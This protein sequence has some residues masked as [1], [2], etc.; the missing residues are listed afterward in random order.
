MPANA[1]GRLTREWLFQNANGDGVGTVTV[2]FDLSNTGSIRNSGTA[3]DYALLIDTDG[4]FSNASIYTTGAS[5]SGDTISFTGV[6]IADGSYISL[7][8][9]SPT[10]P[11]GIGSNLQLWFK[12]DENLTNSGNATDATAWTSRS[13]YLITLDKNTRPLIG[14]TYPTYYSSLING[15]PG[16]TF[17]QTT[18]RLGVS[19]LTNIP[20][21]DLFITAVY[22]RDDYSTASNENVFSYA[23]GT[24]PGDNEILLEPRP[25][26]T[27]ASILHN[28]G[29][30]SSDI[31]ADDGIPHIAT[32]RRTGTTLSNVYDGLQVASGT[33]SNTLTT[34]G[35]LIL[36]E[37]QDSRCGGFEVDNAWEGDIAEEIVY[38]GYPSATEQQQINSYLALKYGITLDQ[39]TPQDYLASDG[40]TEMWNKDATGASTYS[41]DIAGIGRDELSGLNQTNSQSVESDGMFKISNPSDLDDLEFMTWGNDNGSLATGST[42]IPSS[43]LPVNAVIRLGREW[44]VQNGGVGTVSVAIDLT[45]QSIINPY[46]SASNFA[47]L[48]DTDG[49]FSSGSTIHTTGASM[50]AGIIS[51]TG[52]TIADGSY[53]TL[54]GPLPSAPG[55]A[56]TNLNLWFRADYGVTNTGDATDA[57]AWT[58]R[59]INRIVLDHNTTPAIGGT[60]PTYYSNRMNYNPALDFDADT[61]RL[62][63]SGLTLMPTTD[64]FIASVYSRPTLSPE[65]SENLY[66]YGGGNQLMLYFNNNDTISSYITTANTSGTANW[67]DGNP[68]ISVVRRTGSTHTQLFDGAQIMSASNATSVSSGLCLVLGEELDSECGTFSAVQAWAGDMA[69]FIVYNSYPSA[70]DQQKIQTYLA[71]KYGITLDQSGATTNDGTGD[72][73]ASDATVIWDAHDGTAQNAY[74]YDIAGIGQDDTSQLDQSQSKSVNTNAILRVSGATSQDDMDFLVWANN[75]GSATWAYTGAPY[76]YKVLN[77]QWQ[78]Q[79]TNSIGTVDLEFDLADADFDVP[80]LSLGTDYYFIY[81]SDDDGSL[82]DETPVA[83]TDAG[84]NKWTTQLDLTMGTQPGV[85]FTL[86]TEATPL[87]SVDTVVIT[88]EDETD[89]LA[90]TYNLT[91]GTAKGIVDWQV[92]GNSIAFLNMPFEGNDGNESTATPDQS[93]YSNDGTVSGATWSASSGKDGKGAYDFNGSN[94]H[95][96]LPV[97]G[98]VAGHDQVTLEAWI[99]ADTNT[100]D[101]ASIYS[102]QTT[103]TDKWRYSLNYRTDGKLYFGGRDDDGDAYTE[104]VSASINTGTWYHVVALFDAVND[105]TEIYLNGSLAASATPT[106]NAFDSGTSAGR[107]IGSDWSSYFFDGIID[108][109]RLYDRILTVDQI[110]DLYN[111]GTPANENID[112]GMTNADEIWQACVTPNSGVDGIQV[113]SNTTTILPT[114]DTATLP[115]TDKYTDILLTSTTTPANATQIINWKKDQTS[116]DVL[117]MPFEPNGGS[118]STS[119]LD[120]STYGN[121]GAVSGAT[122]S[123]TSGVDGHGAYD[124]NGSSDY[125]SI[126]DDN[127]LDLTDEITLEA[128][129]NLDTIGRNQGF[130]YKGSFTNAFGP[131]ALSYVMTAAPHGLRFTIGN[132]AL[133]LTSAD[134][135]INTWYHVVAT[136]DGQDTP[137]FT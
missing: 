34:G 40:T 95:I 97:A 63:V 7:A 135:T 122:W 121:D 8:G 69:E 94:A 41:N 13:D 30:V 113:C 18:D 49:D 48:I 131:W 25:N 132:E 125:I 90:L 47:L 22:R 36:G 43:G 2:G 11:G 96:S 38:S 37:D 117:N 118:E 75:N 70:T 39:S 4:D 137:S 126:P 51:F 136:Y 128:S 114:V 58:D 91:P 74:R 31:G 56:R 72:Y 109:L 123:S 108:E 44:L 61:D 133:V 99:K 81:D 89:D 83:M 52:V 76:G 92:D 60:F 53:I 35:C 54:A 68:H 124:L 106:I 10:R 85:L 23:T 105:R 102:E 26:G 84:S 101:Y 107:N 32:T 134:L 80:V 104:W 64:M 86:A 27:L 9:P 87:A 116:I 88:G 100:T 57:T 14:G 93:T 111:S 33:N 19:S 21:G 29:V 120:Y 79:E 66:G 1:E 73:L 59:T 65:G 20:T 119:T 50:N 103:T 112:H 45:K 55:G 6:T 5:F 98:G 42:E 12:A 24:S 78:A 15:N 110:A 62:G 16:L 46:A 115:A 28:T 130:I 3:G 127:S 71:L 67:D 82:A 129:V 17:D 77:R